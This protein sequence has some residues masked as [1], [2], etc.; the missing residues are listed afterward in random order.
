MTSMINPWTLA[1]SGTEHGHQAALMLWAQ[2]AM[3]LD[4]IDAL[5]PFSY[6]PVMLV[7]R[8]IV[9]PQL[10]W[11]HAI[12]NGSSRGDTERSRMIRGA[13][14]KAEGVKAGVSD[15]FLPCPIQTALNVKQA[16]AG[17]IWKHGLYIEM[18]KP[19]RG[20]KEAGK[21][22]SKQ[23]EFRKDMKEA[24]YAC[25]VCYTWLEAVATIEAY[26]NGYIH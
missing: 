20:S 21:T 5:N 11:L 16:G 8:P 4:F 22:S 17:W 25:A 9:L 14:L 13:H 23:D 15:V 1:E 26:L 24:G 2:V 6:A 19:K 7:D 18:K 10:K 3:R 12:P